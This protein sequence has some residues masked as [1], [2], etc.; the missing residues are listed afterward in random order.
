MP[1][2]PSELDIHA[3]QAPGLMGIPLVPM[4][5]A[6]DPMAAWR[7]SA[8]EIEIEIDVLLSHSSTTALKSVTKDGAYSG[9]LQC[10]YSPQAA[11]GML[12]GA[13]GMLPGGM[14][15]MQLPGNMAAV[16]PGLQAAGGGMAA[17]G[18]IHLTFGR[19][20][21]LQTTRTAQHSK[22]NHM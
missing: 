5:S 19:T 10:R 15:A 16:Q 1:Y 18:V 4:I 12:P 3:L 8:F 7:V 11:P 21:I 13:F 2:K 6:W 17:P 14:A 22:L 9:T 20:K